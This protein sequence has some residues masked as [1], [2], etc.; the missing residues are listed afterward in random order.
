[1]AIRPFLL[2]FLWA[3]VLWAI[4]LGYA[5]TAAAQALPGTEPLTIAEPLDEVMVDGIDRFAMRALADSVA[6]RADHWHRDYSS[7]A[8]YLKSV[9]ENRPHS[10]QSS[11]SSM[12][13][14]G[15]KGLS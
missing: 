5:S 11:A 9:A 13:D 10:A 2:V 14:R 3:I 7:E 1:M 12:C 6:T 8:A 4:V 15:R